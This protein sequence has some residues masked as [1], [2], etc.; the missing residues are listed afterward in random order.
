MDDDGDNDQFKAN[1]KHKAASH[2]IFSPV[3][4]LCH[5]LISFFICITK[6]KHETNINKC[7]FPRFWF[8]KKMLHL[9][10]II[11]INELTIFAIDNLVKTEKNN[12]I[13]IN[14]RLER[15]YFVYPNVINVIRY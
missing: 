13:E 1:S 14:I 10:E 4:Y 2:F 7:G 15:A 8:F 5:Y 12:K 9:F 3:K 11:M 6:Q